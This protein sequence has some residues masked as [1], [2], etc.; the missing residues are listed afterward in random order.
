[1]RNRQLGAGAETVMVKRILGGVA[2]FAAA[3]ALSV[4][5]AGAHGGHEDF[6][7]PLVCDNGTTYLVEVS[8]NGDFTP[9]R[10]IAST[11]V[12]VPVAFGAF[13]GTLKDPAGN[14][15]ES[16]TEPA[17]SKGNSAKGLKDPVNC[18]FNFSETDEA[19]FTFT[20]SGSAV[21]RMTPSRR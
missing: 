11:S 3:S 21:L 15:V 9:A 20:G 12:F 2:A 10:D 5:P 13:T 1:M 4:G 17:V 18:T 16:F 7:L 6:V 8:G 19:G 14:V